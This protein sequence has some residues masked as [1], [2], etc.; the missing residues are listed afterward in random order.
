M[1][2]F[3]SFL[4]GFAAQAVAPLWLPSGATRIAMLLGVVTLVVAAPLLFFSV[5]SLRRASTP[6]DPAAAPRELV[7]AG[8]YRLTRNPIYLSLV[9][10]QLGV[11]LLMGSWWMLGA[12]AALWALLD[13]LV[14]RDEERRLREAFGGRY[15]EHARRTRRWV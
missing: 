4:F 15:E 11:G 7:T 8:P 12:S 14:V 6:I 3:A 9:L 1:L 10:T 5:S 2:F 13:L